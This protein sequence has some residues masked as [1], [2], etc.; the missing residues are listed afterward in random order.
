MELYFGIGILFSFS[1]WRGAA[2]RRKL[3]PVSKNEDADRDCGAY[4]MDHVHS[5]NNIMI[6]TMG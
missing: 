5:H 2:A 6:M 3:V 4:C 1:F